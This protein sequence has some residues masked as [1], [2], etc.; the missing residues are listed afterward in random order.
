[1]TASEKVKALGFKSVAQVASLI[2]ETRNNLIRW[3]VSKPRR[4]ELILKG[5]LFE[6]VN[7]Q[8]SE[9]FDTIDDDDS[10]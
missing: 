8:I 6:R 10:D 7:D 2:G 5:L 1:V 9:A 4:L 3:N